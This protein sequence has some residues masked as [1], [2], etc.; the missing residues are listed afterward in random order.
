MLDYQKIRREAE[1]WHILTT[2]YNAR[3]IGAYEELVLTVIKAVYPD[4]TE[5]E[6]RLGL[7]Y[8]HDRGLVKLTKEPHG[9]WF[10]ELTRYGVDAVEYTIEMEPGISR[11]ERRS[12]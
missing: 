2:L 6:V 12:T 1:R 8:L 4:A 11:P 9:R 7:D 5:M 10:G 3:P